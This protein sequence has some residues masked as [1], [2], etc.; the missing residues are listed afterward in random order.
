MIWRKVFAMVLVV[1]AVSPTWAEEEPLGSVTT[2]TAATVRNTSLSEGSTV[3]TG[4]VI[5]VAANGATRIALNGGA[6]MEILGNSSVSLQKTDEK[7]QVSVD[8][9][10][11]TFRS[12]GNNG[13]SA[14]VADATIRPANGAETLALVQSLSDTHAIIAATKGALLV[15]TAHDG[16]TYTIS[17]GEAAD[18]SAALE[19]QQNGGAV[20]A[21]RSAPS[22]N[23]RSKKVV[24]W[25]VVILAGGAAAAAIL[26]NRNENQ[27]STTS[28]GNE[29]SPIKIN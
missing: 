2:A 20:P 17:Q 12:L 23:G 22:V 16:K 9:G 26:L 29:V 8:R 5:S 1:A 3:F 15:T 25:T 24:I 4:D 14:L 27:P 13:I 18:L 21:G 11:A 10:Q 7:I 19:P 28:L 6:Q